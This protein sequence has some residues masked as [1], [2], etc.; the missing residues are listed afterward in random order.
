MGEQVEQGTKNFKRAY[1]HLAEDEYN[2]AKAM[3]ESG[4]AYAEAVIR[5]INEAAMKSDSDE[6]AEQA[7]TDLFI[8]EAGDKDGISKFTFR[9]NE[10]GANG[11]RQQILDNPKS[12]GL[13]N[14]DPTFTKVTRP[15]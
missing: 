3:L 13:R 5:E 9:G 8:I 6:L 14:A 7:G 1:N 11:M 15:S 4:V 2:E 12:F 10:K